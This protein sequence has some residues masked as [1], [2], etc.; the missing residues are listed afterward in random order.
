MLVLISHYEQ[1]GGQEGWTV[2]VEIRKSIWARASFRG[3]R[4]W[5]SDDF[6]TSAGV[7][8]GPHDT[9]AMAG[10]DRAAGGAAAL[11]L[12]WLLSVLCGGRGGTGGS[13]QH[14]IRNARESLDAAKVRSESGRCRARVAG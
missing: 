2:P 8:A 13:V 9:A 11:W 5:G 3:L 6:T 12:L 7:A 4:C 10:K 14:V 1:A